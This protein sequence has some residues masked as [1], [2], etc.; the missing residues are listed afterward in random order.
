[1][2]E[3]EPTQVHAEGGRSAARGFWPVVAWAGFLAG[4]WTWVIGLLW[5]ALLVRDF[6]VWGWLAFAVPNVVGAAGFGFVLAKPATSRRVVERHEAAAMRFSEVTICFHVFA[7]GWVLWVLAGMTGVALAAAVALAVW[8]VGFE[9]SR[10]LPAVGL[11]AVVVSLGLGIAWLTGAG[12]QAAL[13]WTTANTIPGTQHGPIELAWLTPALAVGFLLCPYLD[14]TFHRATQATTPA[15]GKAAF[16]IGFGGFFLAMLVFSLLYAVPMAMVFDRGRLPWTV[17]GWASWVLIGHIAL[18]AGLTTGLHLDEV[19]DRRGHAGLHRVLAVAV[20]GGALAYWAVTWFVAFHAPGPTPE[21]AAFGLNP[22]EAIY[23]GFIL[24]YG[25][26]FPAYVW[27]VMLPTRRAVAMRVKVSLWA[28]TLVLTGPLAV[29]AMLGDRYWLIGPA[30]AVLVLG[31][32]AVMLWPDNTTPQEAPQ[33]SRGTTD[34]H[35][36][37]TDDHR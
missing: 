20:A 15:A 35:R 4:S 33:E 18:Q 7:A 12:E 29:L 16:A 24:F 14:L 19:G 30:L 22:A 34:K 5:P 10:A 28:L 32:V 21:P 27:I 13:S 6:D 26:V 1:M 3:A 23:R 9:R 31:R 17:P 11:G 2:V 37:D 25:L 8:V 36:S